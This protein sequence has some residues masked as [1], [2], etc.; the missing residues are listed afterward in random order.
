VNDKVKVAKVTETKESEKNISREVEN[1]TGH[2]R[3]PEMTRPE[4][5]R[6][7]EVGYATRRRHIFFC[8]GSKCVTD[9][10][11][12]LWEYLKS[13]LKKIEPDPSAATVARTKADCLRI[14][15]GGPIALVEPEGILYGNLNKAKLDRIIKEHLIEGNP[16]Q[17][18]MVFERSIVK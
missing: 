16:I 10:N 8:I 17:E 11:L 2:G 15:M 14:C 9:G 12:E 18:W 4:K 13:E 6:A 3:P 7:E 1:S 5:A